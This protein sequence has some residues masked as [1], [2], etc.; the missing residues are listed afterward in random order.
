MRHGA[1]REQISDQEVLRPPGRTRTRTTISGP[2]SDELRNPY[3]PAIP[4]RCCKLIGS[5]LPHQAVFRALT[6][7]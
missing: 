5:A 2:A 1:A 3:R 7:M 6:S 4:F